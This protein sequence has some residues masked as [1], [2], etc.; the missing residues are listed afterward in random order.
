MLADSVEVVRSDASMQ[1]YSA[2]MPPPDNPKFKSPGIAG[3]SARMMLAVLASLPRRANNWSL[4]DSGNN[5]S[6]RFCLG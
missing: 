4:G 5:Q 6:C 2:K 3:I 1:S